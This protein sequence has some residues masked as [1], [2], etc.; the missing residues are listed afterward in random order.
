[1]KFLPI[2]MKFNPELKTGTVTALEA[3]DGG[4]GKWVAVGDAQFTVPFS[5]KACSA[6]AKILQQE[7]DAA[8][9]TFIS[10]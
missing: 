6:I 7:V 5:E 1:M 3:V 9:A 4:E 2:E 8:P 10:K